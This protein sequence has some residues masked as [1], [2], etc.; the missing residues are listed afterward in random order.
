MSGSPTVE[1]LRYPVVAISGPGFLS[2]VPSVEALTTTYMR[3]V[4]LGWYDGMQLV[5]S[6][7]AR[8]FVVKA[9]PGGGV[10]P[11][12]GYSLTYSRRVRIAI[13]LRAGGTV[14][15]AELRNQVCRA[16]ER[17]PHLWESTLAEDGVVGWK[18]KVAR[19]TDFTD[20]FALLNPRGKGM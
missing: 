10:G 19:C 8:Y 18:A 7:L 9:I 12:W 11:L 14:D 5:G 4:R 17:E 2:V 13:E 15:F 3:R 20:L 1:Q 16:M 6:D